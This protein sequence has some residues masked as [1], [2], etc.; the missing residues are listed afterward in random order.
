MAEPT[1]KESI[2]NPNWFKNKVSSPK[3][4]ACSTPVNHQTHHIV[5]GEWTAS[6]ISTESIQRLEQSPANEFMVPNTKLMKP[7]SNFILTESRQKH[8]SDVSQIVD[9]DNSIYTPEEIN[10]TSDSSKNSY[11]ISSS[12][13]SKLD[14]SLIGQ[15]PALDIRNV[16]VPA[17]KT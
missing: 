17:S 16:I 4:T 3:I 2:K 7:Y 12:S 14:D 9:R 6:N 10:Q 15:A 8:Q 11:N 5:S 1:N 13:V